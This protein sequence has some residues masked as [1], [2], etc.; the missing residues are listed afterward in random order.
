MG[1]ISGRA[2][3]RCAVGDR[4]GLG[5]AISPE[6]GPDASEGSERPIIVRREPDHVLLGLRVRLRR[7]LGEAVEWQQAAAI[8]LLLMKAGM[9]CRPSGPVCAYVDGVNQHD[10]NGYNF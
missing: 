5:A 7:I 10:A 8:S 4:L 6:L 9:R 1:C 2:C 3:R